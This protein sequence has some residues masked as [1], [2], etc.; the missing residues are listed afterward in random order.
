MPKE[1]RF[2]SLDH[3]PRIPVLMVKQKSMQHP[4]PPIRQAVNKILLPPLLEGG[5]V[6][7]AKVKGSGPGHTQTL[8]IIPVKD[9]L[10]LAGRQSL[11]ITTLLG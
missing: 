7:V 4:P 8:K 6:T 10:L 11:A 2:P 5:E 1:I 9:M 3:P